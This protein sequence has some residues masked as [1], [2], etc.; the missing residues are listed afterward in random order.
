MTGHSPLKA[1]KRDKG[2]ASHYS[3]S[4]SRQIGKG[5]KNLK[6]FREGLKNGNSETTPNSLRKR[7]FYPFST[8]KKKKGK[9]KWGV[10]TGASAKS[11][12][13]SRM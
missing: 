12:G 4:E 11:K 3:P 9:D 13:G 1:R 10:F 2:V 7:A 6:S 8:R 5:G